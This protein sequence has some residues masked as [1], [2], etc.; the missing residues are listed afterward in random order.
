MGKTSGAKT[1]QTLAA[2]GDT[3]G[4]KKGVAADRGTAGA[5]LAALAPGK[6]LNRLEVA[7]ATGR[8]EA[9]INSCLTRL[10][11]QGRVQVE[12]GFWTL[13]AAGE[14]ATP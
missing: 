11:A 12:G 5:V 4:I 7:Q 14:G 2:G 9:A 6:P 3:G 8:T 13:A 10:R 1:L